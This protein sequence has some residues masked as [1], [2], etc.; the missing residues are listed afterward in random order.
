MQQLRALL[1]LLLLAVGAR[2]LCHCKR[3]SRSRSVVQTTTTF[4]ASLLPPSLDWC[5][6]GFCTPSWNQHIPA[7]CGACYLHGTLSA[8][9]DRIK[10]LHHKRGFTGPDVMLGR[11]SFLNCAPGHG[12]S[13]GCNG[14]EPTDVYEF[15]RIYGLPDETCLPYNA[16]DH[17]KYTWTNGTCPPEG[18]C[19]E[20]THR[21]GC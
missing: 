17:T 11:Q 5:E 9:Q 4:D 16:T 13:D 3:T 10:I 12:F 14:G 18:Y 1:T 8:V 15:M 6:R 2:A 20:Y 19:I 21:W 7:Y